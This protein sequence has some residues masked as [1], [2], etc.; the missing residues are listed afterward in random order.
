M[1]EAGSAML[2]DDEKRERRGGPPLG[3]DCYHFLAL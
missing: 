3:N 2:E 1:S